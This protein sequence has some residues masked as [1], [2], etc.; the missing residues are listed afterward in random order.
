MTS[1]GALSLKSVIAATVG[2]SVG[3]FSKN[4]PL[5]NM[6]AVRSTFKS[7][8]V[9]FNTIPCRSFHSLLTSVAVLPSQALETL[10]RGDGMEA[11]SLVLGF[12]SFGSASTFRLFAIDLRS[13]GA[14]L[15]LIF[16]L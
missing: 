4:S 6:M 7:S 16:G 15:A 12:F 8:A 11:T 3:A 13:F 10:D 14:I 1:A 9:A 5:S 2:C